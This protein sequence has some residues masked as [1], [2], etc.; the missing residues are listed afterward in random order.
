MY[1]FEV[2]QQSLEQ[3]KPKYH[4]LY[5]KETIIEVKHEP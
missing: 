3:D 5:T 1:I 4:E 2:L